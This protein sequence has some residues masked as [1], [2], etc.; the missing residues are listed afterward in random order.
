[1]LGCKLDGRSAK[2]GIDAGGED[3]DAVAAGNVAAAGNGEVDV[4]SFAAADP[5]GLHG[6]DLVGPALELPEAV[7]KLVGVA[8]DAEEP[9]GEVALLNDGI[10][11]TPAAAAH[12]LL[13]GENGLALRGTS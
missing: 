9:L 7:E 12:H 10:F 8:G 13:V 2:D 3:G 5:V 1:M 6:A 4:G 11:V